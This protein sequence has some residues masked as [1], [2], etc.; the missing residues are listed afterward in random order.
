MKVDEAISAA[1]TEALVIKQ[2]YNQQSDDKDLIEQC[3]LQNFFMKALDHLR[4]GIQFS[5]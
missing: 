2:K 1:E 4:T 5:S 3:L